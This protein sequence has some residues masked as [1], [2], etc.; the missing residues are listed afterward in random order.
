M[1]CHQYYYTEKCWRVTINNKICINKDI[2][3]EEDGGH[4]TFVYVFLGLTK[5]LASCLS[6]EPDILTPTFETRVN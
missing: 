4:F 3:R 6:N 5:I 1:R 2:K